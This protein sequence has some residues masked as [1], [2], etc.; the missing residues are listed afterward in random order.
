M[1]GNL[2]APYSEVGV[3]D[4]AAK[5]DLFSSPLVSSGVQRSFYHEILPNAP[6]SAVSTTITFDLDASPQYLDL[7]GSYYYIKLRIIQ[8]S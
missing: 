3:P 5:L 4:A 7:A 6:L 2:A 1:S 8:K